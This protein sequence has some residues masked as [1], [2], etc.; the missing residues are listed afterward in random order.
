MWVVVT[1][2]T[3]D[4]TTVVTEDNDTRGRGGGSCLSGQ[5]AYDACSESCQTCEIQRNMRQMHFIK[6]YSSQNGCP[7]TLIE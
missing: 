4:I 2:V 3:L 1:A 7:P 5:K 6:C